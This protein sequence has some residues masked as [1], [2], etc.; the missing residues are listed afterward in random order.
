[1]HDVG[2]G[3]SLSNFP[4]Q[5]VDTFTWRLRPRSDAAAKAPIDVALANN[6][7]DGTPRSYLRTP[8]NVRSLKLILSSTLRNGIATDLAV[9]NPC[10]VTVGTTIRIARSHHPCCL[11][12]KAGDLRFL[13]TVGDRW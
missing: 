11:S 4:C 6:D 2:I 8:I 1:M 13:R 7:L 10:G 3:P 12:W 5:F 9:V